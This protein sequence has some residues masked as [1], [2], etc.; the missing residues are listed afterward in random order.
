MKKDIF[1]E[2][3]EHFHNQ[4]CET[5]DGLEDHKTIHFH[6]KK[7]ILIIAA[8]VLAF[9]TLT[10]T[11]VELFQWHEQVSRHFGTDKELENK[12]TLEGAAIS[13]DISV[14]N[15][16]LAF[17]AIQAVKT[18]QSYYFL[19][20]MTV[21]DS[22][23]WNND[24]LFRD[25]QIISEQGSESCLVNFVHDSFENH[26]VLLEIEIMTWN[27]DYTDENIMIRLTDLIQTIQTEESAILIK[28][29][30]DISLI[31]PTD[32]ESK[33]YYV[34]KNLTLNGH[35]L[36]IE[37]VEIS[38]FTVRLYIE[39]ET[40][41][42]AVTYQQL[43]LTG[44]KY[45][46]E[47]VMEEGMVR[48]DMAGKT[49]DKEEFYFELALENAI[50]VNQACALIFTDWGKE[51]VF[52]LDSDIISKEYTEDFDVEKEVNNT[53]TAS[54]NNNSVYANDAVDSFHIL[55]VRYN[56]VLLADD[57]NIYLW[58]VSCDRVKQL[59]SLEKY[60][61][62]WEDG[63]EI[64]IGPGSLV[65]VIHPTADSE[66]IYIHDIVY[67]KTIEQ[68]A[69][70]F[71]PWTNYD[72]YNSYLTSITDIL[73]EANVDEQYSVN[74]FFSEEKWYYLYSE[75]GTVEHMHLVTQ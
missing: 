8:A 3:P 27:E 51:V 24:I 16:G 69:E 43:A 49:N 65:I 25:T 18:D 2:V 60:G 75:D 68:T 4:L 66:K 56:N 58:D 20:R 42:H 46:D 52:S 63:G 38:P 48:L 40:A 54:S 7:Y 23:N 21:P 41:L 74:A 45:D 70:G 9:A 22:I 33:S 1:R 67:E 32:A 62:S 50:D 37:R 71:W 19:L 53:S 5:L 34:R 72:V 17:D 13:E 28:G 35:D 31:L 29:E 15:D 59:V 36:Y 73:P 44:I 55:Y 57:K 26:T 12:L 14:Q 64:T 47:T 39:R 30:W 10:V 11:A 61:Y 6:I